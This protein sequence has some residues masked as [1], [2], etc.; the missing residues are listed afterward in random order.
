[1]RAF[2]LAIVGAGAAGLTAAATAAE[3]GVR[4][5]VLDDNALPGGQYFRQLPA[6]Y[7]RTAKTIFDKDQSRAEAVYH[8]TRHPGVAYL[9]EAVVWESPEDGVLSFTRGA[10]SGK[11]R[12]E[13]IVIAA[14]ASD[15]PVPFP[16]W[17]LPGVVTAGGLQNLIKGQRVIPGRRAVVGGNGPL[18]LLV[19]ANLVRAGAQLIE[20]IEAAPIHWRV[21]GEV[22]NLL[23]APK[24]VRQ[25][26][27]YR[28]AILRAGAAFRTGWMVV[29]ARGDGECEEVVVAPINADG[30]VDRARTRTHAAD[31]LV[32]GFGLQPSL[33]LSRGMGLALRWNALRGGWLPVRDQA[34][35]TSRKGV[36]AIGDGAAI[37]GVEIA[38]AEGRLMGL[39]AAER[40]GRLAPAD[41]ERLK[42]PCVAALARLERF[43]S[44]LERLYAPP[45]NYLD[46]LT[47]DTVLC[48]CEEVTAE[49]IRARQADGFANAMQLKFSTRMGMGR[50]QG[51]NCFRTL[52]TIVAAATGAPE[53]DIQ[54]PRAQSPA[55][56]VTFNDLLQEDVEP[57]VPPDLATA[58]LPRGEK[59]N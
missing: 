3:H 53:E 33:E 16:G 46:L 5:A 2:D 32:T 57:P 55:R 24:I 58:H 13:L 27:D 38:L 29:E 36:F 9:S 42:R 1:M 30:H 20:A 43:R 52:S 50:C 4:V 6:G 12:A 59:V 48:R 28:L 41:A 44:A 17:T 39:I 23:A 21:L 49:E 10:D 54:L 25:A 19:S 40:L 8:A 22:P 35:E 37:G 7:R 31:L 47:P 18:V 14:G 11:L 26:F 56:L 34:F 15:R 45:R 51:R